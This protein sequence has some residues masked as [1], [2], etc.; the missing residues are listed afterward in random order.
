MEVAALSLEPNLVKGKHFNVKTFPSCV[1]SISALYS[2][3]RTI[4]YTS[5]IAEYLCDLKTMMQTA[6]ETQLLCLRA[7]MEVLFVHIYDGL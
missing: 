7:V 2:G 5:N 4:L 6:K 3:Q 1:N